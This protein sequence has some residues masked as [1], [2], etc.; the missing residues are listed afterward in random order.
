[1]HRVVNLQLC[2]YIHT[3]VNFLCCC[4]LFVFS[5]VCRLCSGGRKKKCVLWQGT[6]SCG[7]FAVVAKKLVVLL[8]AESS[9]VEVANP[10]H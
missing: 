1:M 4:C 10:R 9:E 7:E 5:D 6:G 8:I 2:K 3:S